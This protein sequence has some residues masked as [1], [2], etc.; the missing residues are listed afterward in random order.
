VL[1]AK[2]VGIHN[3]INMKNKKVEFVN[4][5][6]IKLSGKLELPVNQLPKSYAI[7]AHCFTCNKNLNAV[8]NI[9][10]AL[11]SQGFGVLRF[12]FTGL[13]E[14]EGDFSATDFSSNIEDLEDVAEYMIKEFGAPELLI[15][16]SLG[17]A[18]VIF[19]S[20]KIPSIKSVA[21]VGAPSSPQHVQHLFKSNIEE[22][23]ENGVAIVE[24]GGRSF[25][26]SAQFIEDI[27]GKN[28]NKVLY[29]LNKP[30]LIMHSPQDK[31]VEIKNAAEIYSAAKHPKS[32]IS[33]DGADHLLSKK[34]DSVYAGSVIAQWASRY[35]KLNEEETIKTSEQ[36]VVKIGNKGLTT[37]ILAAGH[38]IT[39]DEPESAGGDNFGPSPY[40]LLLAS[41]GACTAMTLRLYADRKKWNLDEVIIHL[42]HGKTYTADCKNCDEKG[43]K[44]DHIEKSIS[45]IG[46]LDDSQKQRLLEIAD[47]C[48]VHK[49]LSNTIIIKSELK[50]E[51]TRAHKN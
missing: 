13:G 51:V 2:N 24:I 23:K 44:L 45:L 7:F 25:P 19:A 34:E 28:M 31:V 43:A 10:R 22:I 11:T 30:L 26:I 1:I 35:I 3:N 21:T 6:G 5:K 48:P 42:S 27:S 4:S 14:S 8:K 49:S 50:K 37:D 18:A 47:K 40:D 16:H 17:G 36:V 33:L 12:D 32:F 46:N 29:S 38:P 41:L 9:S 15:G 20:A 39:A